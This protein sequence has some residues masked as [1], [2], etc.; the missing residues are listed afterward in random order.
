[1]VFENT[2]DV[3]DVKPTLAGNNKYKGELLACRQFTFNLNVH[4][5]DERF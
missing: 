5:T 1:M 3:A 2:Y 4:G